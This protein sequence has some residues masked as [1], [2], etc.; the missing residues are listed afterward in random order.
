MD[1]F[2]LRILAI[3]ILLFPTWAF[4][5]PILDIEDGQLVGA[6]GVDVEGTLYDVRFVDGSCI[7]LFDGCDEETDFDF[8]LEV[9]VELALQ[10]LLDSVF[11]DGPLGQFDS[12][13]SLTAGCTSEAVC[14]VVSPF[15]FDLELSRFESLLADNGRPDPGGAEDSLNAFSAGVDVDFRDDGRF[16]FALWSESKPVPEPNTLGLLGIG[17]MLCGLMRRRRVL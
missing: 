14:N 11:L 12:Q 9:D 8:D 13:P 5:D 10:A 4:A 15:V 2:Q 1:V 3:S 17:L 7:E 6:S 16:V